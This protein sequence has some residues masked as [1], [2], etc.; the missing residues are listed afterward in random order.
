MAARKYEQH[1]SGSVMIMLTMT[2]CVHQHSMHLVFQPVT[3]N[4]VPLEADK[5]QLEQHD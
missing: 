5:G 4:I 2:S 1:T 3:T